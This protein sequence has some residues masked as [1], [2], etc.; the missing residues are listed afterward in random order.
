[1]RKQHNPKIIFEDDQVLV[2]EK[3]AGLVVNR[4][5]TVKEKTLQ[6]WLAQ[7]LQFFA[8]ENENKEF[9]KR[10]GLVHRLDK[11]TSGLMVVAKTA[12]AYEFLVKQFKE[13]KVL[14]K[15][16]AL[17]HG[18]LKPLVGDI[19][20]P[21]KRHP[22]NRFRF[23]VFVD[24]RPAVT[25]YQV[26]AYYEHPKEKNKSKRYYSLVEVVPKTGRTHQI[27]VH[28]SHLHYPVVSDRLYAGRKTSR[29]DRGWC[30][31]LFLHA[32][33]LEFT[34]V[35]SGKR[36]KFV[37]KLPAALALALSSRRLFKN[38]SSLASEGELTYDRK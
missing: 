32:A 33:Y 2:I 8:G 1:M 9:S 16:L 4:A 26:L 19:Q 15:Y 10:T 25:H 29:Q 20:A 5:A 13:R 18:C 37:S 7:R 28:F 11:E 30:S 24:G 35:T 38:F 23:G 12:A 34:H 27:R 21:I 31:R 22:R 6:D 36:V 14:K 17:I 3:P